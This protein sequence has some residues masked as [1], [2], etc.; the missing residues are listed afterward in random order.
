[1]RTITVVVGDPCRNLGPGVV[2]IEEQ[3]IVEQLIA[4]A[5]LKLSTKPFWIGLPGAIDVSRIAPR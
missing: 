4:H 2:E 1:M 5:P 3:G